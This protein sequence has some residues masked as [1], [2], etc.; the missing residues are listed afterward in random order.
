MSKVVNLAPGRKK[1]LLKTSLAS[2]SGAVGVP[3]SPGKVMRLP[4]M[5]M[6][7]L[8]GL[9]FS[10]K[11]LQT[12]LVYMISF[13]RSVGISLKRMRKKVSVPLTRLSVLSGYVPMTWQSRP[14]LFE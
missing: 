11:T 7:V 4:P 2:S 8:L 14:S 3:T 5:V 12:T 6:R 1:M 13:L 9:L 10:G